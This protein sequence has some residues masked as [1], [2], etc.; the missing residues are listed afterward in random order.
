MAFTKIWKFS[1]GVLVVGFLYS[2]EDIKCCSGGGDKAYSSTTS[3]DRNTSPTTTMLFK[4]TNTTL[5][6]TTTS[7]ERNTTQGTTPNIRVNYFFTLENQECTSNEIIDNLDECKLASSLL[8]LQEPKKLSTT[9]Y[10]SENYPKGCWKLKQ[11]RQ[12][13]WNTHS[14]GAANSVAQAICK[15]KAA[16]SSDND[17]PGTQVCHNV[18]NYI[19]ACFNTCTTEVN[20]S[21]DEFCIDHDQD[22][23][24]SSIC[25]GGG[26]PNCNPATWSEYNSECCSVENPC[27]EGE[28]DCDF[29][30]ECIGNLVCGTDNC[31]PQFVYDRLSTDKGDCCTGGWE[32]FDGKCVDENGKW[33]IVVEHI[34]STNSAYR[35][36]TLCQNECE[37]TN[38]CTA[39]EYRSSRSSYTVCRHYRG[40]PYLGD[41]STTIRCYVRPV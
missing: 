31:G 33:N 34:G 29:E 2:I 8:N 21:D 37:N 27:G 15:A 18:V 5:L 12:S 26:N 17:C 39:F 35:S 16:C 11:S 9:Y 28:G 6:T 23:G 25:A 20:C 22:A 30:T 41:G 36:Y 24:T 32:S 7:T 13:Y 3:V 14:Y 1:L 40:G 19:L 10:K 4:D 38:G